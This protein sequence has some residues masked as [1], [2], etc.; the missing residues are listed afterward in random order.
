MRVLLVA[1]GTVLMIFGFVSGVFAAGGDAGKGKEA[2]DKLCVSCHGKAGK[3]DGVASAAL[4]PKPKD[5][6]DKA[7]NSK[8]SDKYLSDILTKGGPGVGKSPMM[9]P[10]GESLKENDIKNINAY[11]RSLAK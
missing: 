10:F 5:L 7:Y 2:Y 8:L 11:I 1:G 4:N 3:G 6:S 9:P